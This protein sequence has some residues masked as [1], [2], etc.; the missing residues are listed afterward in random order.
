MAGERI[1]LLFPGQGSQAVGMGQELA[2][3]FPAA[4]AVFEQADEALGFP[5]SRLMWEGPAEELTLTANAQ[6]ALLT[7][8]AAVWAV[9]KEADLDVVCAAGHSLGEFSAYHAAGSMSFADAVRTVRRRG[10]LMLEGGN[11]RPGT[12]AAVLGLDDEVVEGVCREAS[13]DDSVVV[14]A[15]FNT[16]GQVVI[17]GDVS[18]VERAGPMLVSAGAKK[19]QPL[20]V[21]GAFHSPLMRVAEGGLQAQ[22]DAIE[23]RDPAFAVV[24]NVTAHAVTEAA[25][26]RTLLVDQ[27]TSPVRW[28]QSVQ[29]M[30]QMGAER[31]LEVGAG[32]V[33]TSMLKR[34]DRA[35]EGR[36]VA[37]G[38]ADAIEK[39]MGNGSA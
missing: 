11:A 9:L 36:G 13:T 37:V 31:F 15:N 33:L 22:L 5:L 6:P 8:S 21:S 35:A 14:P 19:V 20:T 27:L 28:T 39:L 30:L 29:T 3:R 2:E 18:A 23:F 10:E 1:A 16:P 25:E 24:S 7:H 38:T 4:R 34:I 26:A 32:K 12:M 17:S